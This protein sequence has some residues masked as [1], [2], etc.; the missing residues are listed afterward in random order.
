M[1]SPRF[2]S[3]LAWVYDVN[4]E[5]KNIIIKP[6]NGCHSIMQYHIALIPEMVEG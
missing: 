3:N 6:K 2:G 1:V 5:S 4:T